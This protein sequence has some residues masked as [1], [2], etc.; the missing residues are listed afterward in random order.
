MH[1]SQNPGITN[2]AA[3]SW[4][5]YLYILFIPL[6]LAVFVYALF[7]QNLKMAVESRQFGIGTLIWP[8]LTIDTMHVFAT[9]F[10]LKK[11]KV[12]RA[13]LGKLLWILPPLT[14]GACYVLFFISWQSLL[15]VT[16][17]TV[18]FHTVLQQF[19]WFQKSFDSFVDKSSYTLYKVIFFACSLVPILY[20]HTG[21]SGLGTWYFFNDVIVIFVP[22]ELGNPILLFAYSAIAVS[23][24]L[25]AFRRNLLLKPLAILAVTWFIYFYGI[26]YSQSLLF[27][28]MC[29]VFS[30]AGGYIIF[31]S[32][33]F[34]K[35]NNVAS[36]RLPVVKFLLLNTSVLIGV[37]IF[38]VYSLQN[39]LNVAYIL[40][41]IQL[42]PTVLHL[43]FDSL[44]WRKKFRADFI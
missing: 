19:G 17:Y 13:K 9:L 24:G 40:I 35:K 30:H 33:Y 12:V 41:P 44:V 3:L 29:L 23:I 27:F 2:A 26:V 20:W 28:I 21:L 42:A 1:L 14:L 15:Q 32:T 6:A 8:L 16:A 5:K 43:V 22:P 25:L 34:I 18:L 36:S 38:W 7:G 37:S 39:I 11:N 10:F 31:T 4:E